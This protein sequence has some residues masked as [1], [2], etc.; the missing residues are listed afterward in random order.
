MTLKPT[1][2][3]RDVLAGGIGVA[4]AITMGLGW[5]RTAAAATG[6]LEVSQLKFG[7]VSWLLETVVA[8][9]LAEKNGVELKINS[10]ATNS[11]S[12]IGLMSGNFDL[13]VSDWPWAMVQRSRGLA[14]QFA[15]YSSALG[16]LMVSADSPIKSIDD[17]RGKR[18]AV[19]GSAI[20]K[21]WLLMR[22]YGLKKLDVD[23]TDAT[24]PIFGAPPLVQ[25]QLKSGRVDAALNFW[26]FSAKLKGI[27]YRQIVSMDEV[28]AELG[29]APVP[30]LVG[31]VWNSERLGAK[32]KQVAGFHTAIREANEILATSDAAWERVRPM[33]RAKTDGEFEALIAFY[34]A[35]IPKRW[36]EAETESAENL[37]ALLKELGDRGLSGQETKFDAQLFYGA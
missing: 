10:V 37:M 31:F 12:Q 16:A 7:S 22:A 14:M 35:G 28:L 34:R 17:V 25:Q 23:F 27:G 13:I 11:A 30:P 18:I 4:S 26:T 21:S 33:M 24:T 19:A 36:T 32:A 6:P 20:D 3:R 29:V 15:P 2:T 5:P 8:E 9:G 1:T